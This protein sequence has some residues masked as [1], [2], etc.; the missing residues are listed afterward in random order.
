MDLIVEILLLLFLG[1]LI[2]VVWDIIGGE[3]LWL[4]K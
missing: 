4:I 1:T 3:W 2:S